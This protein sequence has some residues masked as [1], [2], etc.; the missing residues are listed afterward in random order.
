MDVELFQQVNHDLH[1]KHFLVN[2]HLGNQNQEND[3]LGI[4]VRIEKGKVDHGQDYHH[5]QADHEELVQVVERY[6]HQIDCEV[7]GHA[8]QRD[9]A[10]IVQLVVIGLKQENFDVQNKYS[11]K[12]EEDKEDD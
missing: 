12:Q 11:E 3:E 6:F 1:K 9:A 7:D 8:H 2:G 10:H 5:R 4:D